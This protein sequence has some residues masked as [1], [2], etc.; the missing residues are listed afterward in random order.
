MVSILN[1]AFLESSQA[2]K[3]ME[4]VTEFNENA[5]IDRPDH[6]YMLDVEK[7]V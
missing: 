2:D 3:V 6:A 5:Q 7:M 1:F 4:A